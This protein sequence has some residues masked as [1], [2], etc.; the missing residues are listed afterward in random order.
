MKTPTR[1]NRSRS[2]RSFS[3][4]KRHREAFTLIEVLVV[5]AIIAL[6]LAILLP[7]MSKARE[8]S[9]SALC[10]SNLK[11]MG[12]G[13]LMYAEAHNTILPGPVHNPIYHDSIRLQQMDVQNNT[14][15]YR[16]N[17]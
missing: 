2:I 13:V 7:S 16:G 11:Q 10:L 4:A 12:L 14:Y 6:L 1:C 9:R 3:G 8:S 17:L 5:V 15:N